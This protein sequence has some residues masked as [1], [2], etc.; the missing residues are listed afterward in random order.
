MNRKAGAEE[1]EALSVS[2][3]NAHRHFAQATEVDLGGN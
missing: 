2:S 1:S 3:V